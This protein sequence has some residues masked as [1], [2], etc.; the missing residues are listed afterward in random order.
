M[1]PSSTWAAAQEKIQRRVRRVPQAARREPPLGG[2]LDQVPAWV[3]FRN[4]VAAVLRTWQ[5]G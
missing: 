3:R 2:P 5:D 4:D 1:Q